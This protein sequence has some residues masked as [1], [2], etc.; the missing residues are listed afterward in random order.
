MKRFGWIAVL[1]AVLLLAG[2]GAQ[3]T[4]Q[5]VT[6]AKLKLADGGYT[7]ALTLD[8]GSGR[9]TVL[10][11]ADLDIENGQIY[12]TVVWSSSNYDYM[13]M[14]GVRYDLISFENGSTFR[15]P[16]PGFDAP[17]DV[18]G[19]T[20]AMSMPHEIEYKLTLHSG[21]LIPRG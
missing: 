7:A 15:L 16:F 8:G 3:T 9:A 20:V 4:G 13:V 19:D 10:S 12:L 21:S 2:C 17:V 14:D 6:A 1:L 11:P 18:I 5:P